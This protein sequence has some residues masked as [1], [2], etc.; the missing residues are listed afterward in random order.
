M[1]R[2][3]ALVTGGS[4]GIGLGIAEALAKKGWDLALCGLRE[5]SAVQNVVDELAGAGGSVQYVRAD[6]TARADRDRLVDDV[7]AR[8]SRIDALVNNAGRAPRTRTDVLETTEV[9]FAEVMGT[10]LQGPFFLTQAVAAR[11]VD[12]RRRDPA[13]RP[14]IVFITSVSAEMASV[15]RAEYCLSKAG[16]AMT[17]KVFALRLA[18]EGIPV[19]E[20]RPGI[21]ETDM[22]AAVHEMYTRRIADGLVPSGRWGQPAD[23]GAVVASILG[24]EMAFATGSVI[25]VAGGLDVARL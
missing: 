5:A 17:V 12:D 13:A 1:R 22:T 24:G 8:Y 2:P 3:V 7:I 20:V 9:S 23:V 18:A 10:N 11:M 21:I 6:V 16:L 15:N 14:S 19:F 25:S 4:R